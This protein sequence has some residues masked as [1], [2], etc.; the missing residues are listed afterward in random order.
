MRKK[1]RRLRLAKE[2]VS[3]LAA[4]QQMNPTAHPQ[5]WTCDSS[6]CMPICSFS[7]VDYNGSVCSGYPATYC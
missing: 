7:C 4:A 5:T 2:T 3:T 6:A 1:M